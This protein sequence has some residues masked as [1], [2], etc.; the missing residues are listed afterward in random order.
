MTYTILIDPDAIN[1][2][3][4]AVNYYDTKQIGIGKRFLQSRECS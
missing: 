4:D 1:D 3:Q 2:I